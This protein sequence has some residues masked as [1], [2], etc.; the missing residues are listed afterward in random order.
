MTTLAV[1]GVGRLVSSDFQGQQ[2][3][4]P[5]GNCRL[6]SSD[7]IWVWVNTYR[8]ILVGRTSIY[9]LFWGSLGTRVLTHPHITNFFWDA[10][11][12]GETGWWDPMHSR[13]T[14]Q[15]RDPWNHP[16]LRWL[17]QRKRWQRTRRSPGCRW[18][19]SFLEQ[20]SIFMIC[21]MNFH[22]SF[23]VVEGMIHVF[24]IV[25][26]GILQLWNTQKL[27][28]KGTDSDFGG[29]MVEFSTGQKGADVLR[30]FVGG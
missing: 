19:R 26:E 28:E 1:I 8:Y 3:N 25:R 27:P 10:E 6:E 20:H 13:I 30:L 5:E 15:G 2:V 17:R 21:W 11:S 14:W 24:L 7:Y 9:Q 16:Q 4:L 23:I 29:T 18:Q 22:L 12:P